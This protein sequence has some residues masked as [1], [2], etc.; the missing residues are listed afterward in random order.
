MKDESE[1]ADLKLKIQK[2]EIMSSSPITSWQIDGETIEAVIDF[3]LLGSKITADGDCSHEIERR[4]YLG[5]KAIINIDGILKTRDMILPAK[6][7]IV[8]AMV[9]SSSLVWM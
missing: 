8:K 5:R 1:K 4:L 7:Y 9:F 3:N 6:V 2:A